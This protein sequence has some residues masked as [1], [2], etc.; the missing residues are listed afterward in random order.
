MNLPIELL[1]RKEVAQRLAVSVQS[2]ARNEKRLG[3]HRARVNLNSRLIRYRAD[4]VN[5]IA[6]VK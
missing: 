2:V 6:S 3:L 1:T 4:R 5:I